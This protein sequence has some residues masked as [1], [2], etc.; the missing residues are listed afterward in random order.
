ME[1]KEHKSYPVDDPETQPLEPPKNSYSSA[2]RGEIVWPEPE[3]KQ[4]TFDWLKYK[5]HLQHLGSAVASLLSRGNRP[6]FSGK[7]RQG[8]AWKHRAAIQ[9][10]GRVK[11][12]NP[13]RERRIARRKKRQKRNS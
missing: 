2:T 9:A 10:K 8:G 1:N 3:E 7:H 5:L 12:R 13:E 6:A 11:Q 4:S